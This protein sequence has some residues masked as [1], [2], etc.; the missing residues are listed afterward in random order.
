MRGRG[1]A[2]GPML[3]MII[4]FVGVRQLYLFIITHIVTGNPMVI[5]LGYPVGW[6]SCFIVELIYYSVKHLKK[7]I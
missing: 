3:I 4:C 2:K 5:G 7:S 6:A 1:D